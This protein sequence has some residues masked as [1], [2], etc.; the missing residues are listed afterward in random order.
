MGDEPESEQTVRVSREPITLGQLLK[1]AG[2]IP[3][4]GA[5]K[6]L[7]LSG[8]VRVDGE[9]ETRRGRKLVRG[10]EVEIGG[11]RIRLV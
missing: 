5:A 8:A 10:Q 11:R 2:V 6:E 4:G 7:L 3:T 9:V 1:L